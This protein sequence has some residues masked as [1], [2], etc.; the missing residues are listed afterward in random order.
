MGDQKEIIIG[1]ADVYMYEFSGNEI[2]E[3]ST[4]ETDEHL[5]GHT[6]GGAS[7]E[8][9]PTKYDV[10]NSY[11]KIVLSTVTKEEITAKTGLLSWRLDRLAMLSTAKFAVDKVKKIRTLVFEGGN[12]LPNVLIHFVHTKTNGKKLRFTM[13]GQGGNGF[14]I[15]FENKETTVDAEIMAVEY[16]KNF[17]AKFEEELTDEEAEAVTTEAEGV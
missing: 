11:G 7:V 3:S 4:I 14:T 1:A 16:I 5:V 6:S 12:K 13:V 9:K 17:L 15:P 10:E 8:Y 2:P